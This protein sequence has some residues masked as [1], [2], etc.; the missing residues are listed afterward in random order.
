MTDLHIMTV[1]VQGE[2]VTA[3]MLNCIIAASSQVGDLGRAYQT[4]DAAG[5]L[6]VVPTA[7]TYNAVMGGCLQWGEVPSVQ[8]ASPCLPGHSCCP[9]VMSRV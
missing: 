5:S 4:F 7:D 6:G 2:G 1:G 9:F 3:A 8:K